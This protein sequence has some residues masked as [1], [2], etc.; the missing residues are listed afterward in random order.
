MTEDKFS[1]IENEV[2][3]NEFNEQVI[4]PPAEVVEEDEED[5]LALDEMR[6]RLKALQ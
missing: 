4:E 3:S 6:E 5:E 2:P 1:K